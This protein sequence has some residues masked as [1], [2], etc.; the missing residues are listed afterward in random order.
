[1][2]S[3]YTAASCDSEIK[4]CLQ[5][6]TNAIGPF[7]PLQKLWYNLI[8][9]SSS[10]VFPP[11]YITLFSLQFP[12]FMPYTSYPSHSLLLLKTYGAFTYGQDIC[13]ILRTAEQWKR[14]GTG[15]CKK[16]FFFPVNGTPGLH[17]QLSDCAHQYLC[18]LTSLTAL[19]RFYVPLPG[20]LCQ[21]NFKLL[22]S[23][24]E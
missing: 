8:L 18:K 5:L 22:T 20:F 10:Q 13:F 21:K 12:L 11:C 6:V 17:K 14:C 7:Q 9:K 4:K 23:I 3:G 2:W 1:M 19:E 16:R 24:P 15:P